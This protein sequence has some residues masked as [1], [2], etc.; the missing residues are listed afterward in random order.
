MKIYKF[1]SLIFSMKKTIV[2]QLFLG[3]PKY[4]EYFKNE[5]DIG[6]T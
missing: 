4:L 6:D 3:F 5:K 2:C 1:K